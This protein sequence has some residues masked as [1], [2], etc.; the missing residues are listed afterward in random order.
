MGRPHNEQ[1]WELF[2]S[3]GM[4]VFAS[5]ELAVESFHASGGLFP[6]LRANT[7]NACVIG[8]LGGSAM[9]VHTDDPEQMTAGRLDPIAQVLLDLAEATQDVGVDIAVDPY[10]ASSTTRLAKIRQMQVHRKHRDRGPSERRAGPELLR[11]EQPNRRRG[12]YRQVNRGG[13]LEL[14]KGQGCYVPALPLD[15]CRRYP[16][17]RTLMPDL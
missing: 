6:N 17:A 3:Y 5:S 9:I 12:P 1:A 10:R 4:A 2:G 15:A 7:E 8:E 14:R 13:T 11:G 16:N